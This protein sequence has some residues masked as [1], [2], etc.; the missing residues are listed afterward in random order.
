MEL[1]LI[2]FTELFF[3]PPGSMLVLMLAGYIL[4]KRYQRLGKL[5][6]GLGLVL[7][8]LACL[9]MVTNPL[10]RYAEDIPPLTPSQITHSGAQAIVVL[11]GGATYAPEYNHAVVKPTAHTRVH[12]A[13]LLQRQN[14]LPILAAG[15]SVFGDDEAEAIIIKRII[16]QDYHGT[17][18]WA[19]SH[20]RNTYENAEF[21]YAILHKAG[22]SKII[23]V[24]HALHMRRSLEVF[25]KAGFSV[26]PA[27]VGY[28]L[29]SHEPWYIQLAPQESSLHNMAELFHEW[30]GR[31]WYR[32]RY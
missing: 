13:V 1:L 4:G 29:L 28:H 3:V 7:L 16:E 18:R 15:G 30:L 23:L 32:L 5:L 12:Y 9:P 27:P 20:S 10:M 2:K 11:G 31:V 25:E 24:T 8:I 14:Q 22:I 26:I 17:V 6:L 21:S 19:E